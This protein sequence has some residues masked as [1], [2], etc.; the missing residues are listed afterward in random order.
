MV[1]SLLWAAARIKQKQRQQDR[2]DDRS[3]DAY[4]IGKEQ[5]LERLSSFEEAAIRET[6]ASIPSN[7]SVRK[8][9]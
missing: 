1:S 4:P 9:P 8:S 2:H 5:E 6:A 7:R 3:C